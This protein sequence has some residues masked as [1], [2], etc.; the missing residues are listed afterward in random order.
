MISLLPVNYF[1]AAIIEATEKYLSGPVKLFVHRL[2]AFL[3]VL[4]IDFT[5]EVSPAINFTLG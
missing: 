1:I 3:V 5:V 4:R 2:M